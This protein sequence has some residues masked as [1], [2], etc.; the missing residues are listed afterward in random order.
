MG[1]NGAMRISG[2]LVRHDGY[3]R[4]GTNDERTEGLRVQ[5]MT[6]LTPRLTVR[7]S[8]DYSHNGGRGSSL[9][10]DS[11]YDFIGGSYVRRLSGLRSEERRVGNGWFRQCRT[12]WSPDRKKKKIE[13][14][15]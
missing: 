14:K 5:L 15:K 6:E 4:D 12:R 11:N 13:R 8:G 10:Y 2:T 9:S 1:D 7:L 3:L